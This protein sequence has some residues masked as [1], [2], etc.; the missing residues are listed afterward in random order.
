M[1][2]RTIKR[3][4]SVA[5]GATDVFDT[6]PVPVGKKFLLK[7]ICVSDANIGDHKST[8]YE[9]MFGVPGSFTDIITCFITGNVFVFDVNE[10]F[11]GDGV[12][13]FRITRQNNSAS[14]K[15]CPICIKAFV[16]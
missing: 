15:R 7:T 12:K 1:A 4:S 14:A 3:F 5:A 2:D 13:F 11:I 16:R 8:R 9:V 10:E 6:N